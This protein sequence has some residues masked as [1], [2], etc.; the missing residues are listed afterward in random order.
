[1]KNLPDEVCSCYLALSLLV[2]Y[3]PVCLVLGQDISLWFTFSLIDWVCLV[4]ISVGTILSQTYRY[5]AIK[6]YT[7]TGLQPYTFIQ[8]MQ[9]FL[10]DVLIFDMG[11]TWVQIVGVFLLIS[12]DLGQGYLVYTKSKKKTDGDFAKI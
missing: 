4:G 2:I 1:M 9:Q 10:T 6:I 7:I 3:L 12:T 5:K 11:F 8:P